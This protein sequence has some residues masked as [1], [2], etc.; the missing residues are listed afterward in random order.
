MNRNARQ[1]RIK[2][3][4]LSYEKSVQLSRRDLYVVAMDFPEVNTIFTI[5]DDDDVVVVV[6]FE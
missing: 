5:D 4:R 3:N 1:A 6:V 2:L